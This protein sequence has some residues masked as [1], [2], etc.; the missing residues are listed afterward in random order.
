[1]K[2]YASVIKDYSVL[3]AATIMMAVG[4]YVFKFPNNFTFGGV[5]GFAVILTALTGIKAGIL[6]LFINMA[7]LAV[8]FVFL[9]KNFGIRTVYVSVLLSVLLALPEKLFPLNNPLT[10][11]PVLELIFAIALPAA[12]SAVLFNMGA[13]S[14]GTDIVAMIFKKYTSINIGTSLL[15]VDAL[16][17]IAAFAVFG[18]ETGLYSLCGLF[19]KSFVIDGAIEN[20]NLCKYFTIVCSEPEPVCNYIHSSLKRG[21]T[22]F[23][24]VGTYSGKKEYV[25]LTVV[26]RSEAVQLR[27]FVRSSEPSAFMMITNSSEI[28]GKGFRGVL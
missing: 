16:A 15:I 3:T 27:N 20:I 2:K 4:I 22:M 21:A 9:G 14:G 1:M 7:L 5:T 17:V 23:E 12:S 28:I 18:V 6:S 24:A 19:F 25:I 8:G 26:R 13:S 11:Q 10:S